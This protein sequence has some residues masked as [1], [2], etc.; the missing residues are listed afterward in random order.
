MRQ[1]RKGKAKAEEAAAIEED[2]NLPEV[3][4]ALEAEQLAAAYEAA[5]KAEAA[6]AEQ[7]SSASDDAGAPQDEVVDWEDE[8]AE[9]GGR[10]LK[11]ILESLLF[12]SDKPL[13][14]NRLRQITHAKSNVLVKQL[15]DE[16]VVE[17]ENRGI[18]LH[19]VAGAYQFRT[20]PRTSSW[21]QK[22]VA[23][24]PV[25]LS[26]AQLETLAIIAYRQPITRPEIDEIRGVD[27]GGTLRVLLDRHLIRILGK[28]EEPGRP[29]L[30]G[31]S[32]EFLEFFNLNELAE[33]PT[34]REYS[35]LSEDSM[36]EVEERLGSAPDEDDGEGGGGTGG[37]GGM[38]MSPDGEVIG[39]VLYDATDGIDVS[40]LGTQEGFGVAVTDHDAEQTVENEPQDG[41]DAEEG[42]DDFVDASAADDVEIL[43]ENAAIAAEVVEVIAEEA[44]EAIAEE[45]VEAI[46][47]ET[48]AISEDGG[49][50]EVD[51]DDSSAEA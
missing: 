16:L 39:E 50:A 21:V 48:A 18:V 3:K 34:L 27:S 15:L 12:A 42:L 37:G 1:K 4:E 40:P 33:L 6:L 13:T 30:Y 8:E 24:R 47:D 26:R 28:K 45:T 35:E 41:D 5:Q 38:S 11:T 7:A 51:T 44:V 31:T 36:R 23:G 14:A 22:L 9:L 32:K 29:L 20:H 2:L 10:R 25:R 43:D 46:A 49:A 17:Y 19:C